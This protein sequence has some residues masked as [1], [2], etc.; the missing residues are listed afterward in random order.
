M[1]T[2]LAI[3]LP[4]RVDSDIGEQE[5]ADTLA[6]TPPGRTPQRRHPLARFRARVA[7]L[8]TTVLAA[9]C[10]AAGTRLLAGFLTLFVAFLMREHPLPGLSG[11]LTLALVAG[12]A[13][14]GNGLGTLVGSAL[15][16]RRPEVI[17]AASLLACVVAALVTAA[18]YSVW[19]LVALGL[20]A[21]LAGQTVKL[22]ADAVVQRDVG[23]VGAHAGL[24]LAETTL[25]MAWVVGG[26]IGIALPLVPVLGF[27]VVSALLVVVLLVTVWVRASHIGTAPA[28]AA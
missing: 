4:A 20:V 15:G 10:S 19:T 3:R 21:G 16:H 8:P 7:V 12:A 2:V 17:T 25:Q 6:L 1:G 14:V 9:M 28:P 23:R 27:G 22:G 18:F 24:R 26:G 11:T 13:G 5:I